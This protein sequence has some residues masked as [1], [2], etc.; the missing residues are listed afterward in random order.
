MSMANGP[1]IGFQ[2]VL[3]GRSRLDQEAMDVAM[4]ELAA[5]VAGAASGDR[6][7][8]E[9]LDN[10]LDDIGAHCGALG[11]GVPGKREWIRKSQGLS[12]E[13]HGLDGDDALAWL[14]QR[15]GAALAGTGAQYRLASLSGAW[16]ED[17]AGVLLAV[18]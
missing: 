17:A 15:I 6:E 1:K 2:E 12:E 9:T 3:E 11:R 4:K 7:T 16:Y 13:D 8:A 18:F 10:A 5:A 14:D